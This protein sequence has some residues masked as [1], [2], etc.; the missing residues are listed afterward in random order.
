MPQGLRKIGSGIIALAV[1]LCFALVIATSAAFIA[2][3]A[4][5]DCAGENCAVCCQLAQAHQG[6]RLLGQGGGL[7]FT[8]LALLFAALFLLFIPKQ[9]PAPISL[10]TQK[11]QL[12]M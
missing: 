2:T 8:C 10:I 6:L 11:V 1:L 5:H 9:A 3:H 7:F 4:D 12:N